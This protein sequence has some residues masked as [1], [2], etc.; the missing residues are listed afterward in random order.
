MK[1]WWKLLVIV[2]PLVAIVGAW[3]IYR[4]AAQHRET[5][6]EDVM[7]PQMAPAMEGPDLAGY[8]D[9]ISLDGGSV[10]DS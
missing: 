9:G 2:V 5:L 7:V 1:R 6:T 3:R 4:H 8:D 10:R